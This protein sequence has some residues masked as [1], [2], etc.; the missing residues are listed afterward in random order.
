MNDDKPAQDFRLTEEEKVRVLEG[1]KRDIEAAT[2]YRPQREP[3]T[4][5]EELQCRLD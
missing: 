2:P 1:A 3:K 5:A 4:P